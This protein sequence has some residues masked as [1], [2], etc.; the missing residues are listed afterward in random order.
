M[1]DELNRAKMTYICSVRAFPASSDFS[2]R[3]KKYV[4]HRFNPMQTIRQNG[5]T[6]GVPAPEPGLLM[7]AL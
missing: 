7:T 2:I 6:A 1:G 3:T 4:F 5:L